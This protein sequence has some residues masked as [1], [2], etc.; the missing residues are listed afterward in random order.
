VRPFIGPFFYMRLRLEAGLE[1]YFRK[2]MQELFRVLGLG[3]IG[4]RVYWV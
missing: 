1:G 4:F 3:F 2:T